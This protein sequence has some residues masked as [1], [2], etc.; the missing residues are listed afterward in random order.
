[1]C[2]S[3]NYSLGTVCR[4]ERDFESA[5]RHFTEAYNKWVSGD[6]L[7]SDPFC[8]ACV[9]RMGCAALDQDKV[10]TA[11]YVLALLYIQTSCHIKTADF[12]RPE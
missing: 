3:I 6:N 2:C 4:A 5:E 12:P 7:L 10:E 1:M 9:Y 8:G 11:M